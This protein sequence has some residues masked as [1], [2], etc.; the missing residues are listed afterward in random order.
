MLMGP[1]K[2]ARLNLFLRIDQMAPCAECMIRVHRIFIGHGHRQDYIPPILPTKRM[3]RPTLTK[4]LSTVLFFGTATYGNAQTAPGPERP[5]SFDHSL[6]TSSRGGPFEVTLAPFVDTLSG[7]CDNSYVLTGGLPEGGSYSGTGV[8]NG[9]FSPVGL[10]GDIII[11]YTWT[12]GIDTA[13][14]EQPIHVVQGI[15]VT[16]NQVEQC[17]SETPVQITA[18][19]TPEV[20]FDPII[21]PEGMLTASQPFQGIVYSSWTDVT[22]CQLY[23]SVVVILKAYSE[24]QVTTAG[25]DPVPAQVCL[26]APPFEITR[27]LGDGSEELISFDPQNEGPGDYQFIGFAVDNESGCL[28]NDTLSFSVVDAPLVSVE[29]FADTLLRICEE[30]AYILPAGSPEGGTWSGEGVVDGVFYP[31]FIPADPMLTYTVDI[32]SGCIG[33]DSAAIHLIDAVMA[34][35][36]DTLIAACVGSDPVQYY[37]EPAGAV[38]GPA[39]ISQVGYVDMLTPFEGLF[40]YTYTDA[41]G[42]E[43]GA[44]IPAIISSYT[45]GSVTIPDS[46]H[47]V[48]QDHPGILVTL[49]TA[50]G[51]GVDTVF[52]P[53]EA[54]PGTYFFTGDAVV[55]AGPTQCY[56]SVTDSIIVLASPDATLDLSALF[57]LTNDAPYPLTEGLPEG[58]VYAGDF[59]TDGTFDPAAAGQGWHAVTYTVTNV[60]LCSTTVTDSIL[61]E[62]PDGIRSDD[63]STSMRAWPVPAQDVLNIGL[64]A[65]QAAF[66][67]DLV[68]AGGRTALRSVIPAGPTGRTTLL[69]VHALPNGTYTLFAR[70]AMNVPPIRITLAR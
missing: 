31:A 7:T 47:V 58:G 8:A 40:T 65:S 9:L 46:V 38:W 16:P 29:A 10:E 19:P 70:G 24:G 28:R 48:C 44:G 60:D 11:T 23:G 5:N 66:S 33:A 3:N 20:W 6:R 14:A 1:E 17:V 57:L 41:A 62:L 39:P 64:P 49:S 32:G 2:A 50:D 54:G 42:C 53:S 4:L 45:L 12:D 13:A 27:S 18:V 36:E 34:F 52:I 51:I 25:L 21:S 61:V 59:V 68:D 15:T 26:N 30:S 35:P 37:T 55:Q 67:L 22:G 69:A 56:Q 43:D 63:N